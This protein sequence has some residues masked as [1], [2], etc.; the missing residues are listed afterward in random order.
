MSRLLLKS[1][2]SGGFGQGQ[3]IEILPQK[4]IACMTL[5]LNILFIITLIQT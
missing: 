4:S 1:S 3:T 5:K 2:L